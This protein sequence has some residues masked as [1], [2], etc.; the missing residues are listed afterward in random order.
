[1]RH[2]LCPAKPR[3]TGEE[4]HVIRADEVV[5]GRVR[6]PWIDCVHVGFAAR[7]QRG[8]MFS[9]ELV[10]TGAECRNEALFPGGPSNGLTF[11]LTVAIEI[12]VSPKIVSVVS[13]ALR[14]ASSLLE[15]VSKP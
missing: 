3:P 11:V 15:G 14:N 13:A 4:P 10:Q 12:P 5:R 7:E 1:M 9:R 8:P 2:L 6:S